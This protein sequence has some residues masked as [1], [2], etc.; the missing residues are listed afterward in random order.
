MAD[1]FSSI[2]DEKIRYKQLLYMAAKNTPMDPSLQIQQNKVEGCL[3]VVHVH[4][5]YHP[6][7]KTVFFVG[8]SDGQLT[9]G[10]VS[11]LVKGLS[12]STVEEI[13]E[14]DPGF[15]MACGIGGSLTPSRNNGFLNMLSMMKLKARESFAAAAA[16]A[17]APAPAAAAA[18]AA[19]PMYN[20]MMSRLAMLQPT[21]LELVDNS[22]QHAGHSGA[23][24]FSGESHFALVVVADCFEGLRLL[25]R[26]Q[27]SERV[28]R[29][30]SILAMNPA[31]LLQTGTH[32]HY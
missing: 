2:P 14:V 32:I 1:Q 25:K 26:H 20:E 15:I 18:P 19:G 5:T 13:V 24:G 11:L 21:K 4:A 22:D 12:G 7:T 16:A 28:L 29:K 3:S 30:T 6:D 23:R 10:L 27:V 17:A 31:K 9:K 8:D